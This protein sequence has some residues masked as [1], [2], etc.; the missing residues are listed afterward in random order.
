[1]NFFSGWTWGRSAFQRRRMGPLG[2]RRRC[3][4]KVVNALALEILESRALPSFTAPLGYDAGP[5]PRSVAVG[6]FN[7]D[8]IPDLAVANFVLNGTVSVL[9][10]N[11]DGSFQRA[12]SFAAGNNPVAVAVGDLTGN[13]ILDLVVADN[14]GIFGTPALNVLLGNGD[15]TFQAPRTVAPGIQPGAVAVGDFNGDG[16]QD[17]AVANG[18]NTVSMFLGNGDGSFRRAM[19]YA[20]GSGPDSIA[21]GDFNHDGTLDLAVANYFN[22]TVSVLLGIGDGSF[23]TARNFAAERNPTSVAVGDFTGSGRLDLAVANNGSNTVSV[24]LGNGDGSFQRPHNYTVGSS[25]MMV[26]VGDFIGDGIQDLAVTDSNSGTISVLLGAGNGSFLP[27]RALSAGAVPYG[28]AVGDFNGDGTQDLA[29]TDLTSAP[30][31]GV[32]VL[33]GTGT[34]SFQV[35]PSFAVGIS[36]ESVAVADLNGDG[37]PDLVVANSGGYFDNGSVS[38]LLGNGDGSF[39]PARSFAVGS[40]PRS[41][42]VGDFN[43]DGIPDL[44]VANSGSNNVSVLLGNG[45]GSFQPAR[46]FAV[47]SVPWSVAAADLAGDGVLDLV[48][49]NFNANDVSILLGTG[50][51]TFQS[52]RTFAAGTRPRSVAV[53]DFDG[54]GI[55]DL[56]VA[57]EGDSVTGSGGGVSILRGTGGGTFQAARRFAAGMNPRSVAVGDFN[58]DGTLDLAVA[59]RANYEGTPGVSVLL[60]T[61]NG[62]FQPARTFAAG[63]FPIAV[64][65]GDFNGDGIQDLAVAG[66]GGTRVLLGTGNGTFQTTNVSYVTGDSAAV[67]VGDFNGDGL[68][69]LAAAANRANA[70]F[71]LANDGIWDSSPGAPGGPKPRPEPVLPRLLLENVKQVEAGTAAV[72]S[73]GATV[74]L[75]NGNQAPQGADQGA[76]PVAPVA[77]SATKPTPRAQVLARAQAMTPWLVDR[78]LAELEADGLWDPFPDAPSR[79]GP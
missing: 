67:A 48:V 29:V 36:P 16:I 45:D 74:P 24:L 73:P 17:L 77:V 53:G 72:P 63:A 30:T 14:G 15:G 61:G 13:G 68:P 40:F 19:D 43:G 62:T 42:A 46:S 27:A 8:G 10:G 65:V 69:D 79:S 39:R 20:V 3:R 51:G 78:L 18:S 4:G 32:S 31:G 58:G 23:Q 57:D 56:A 70:V 52:A 66:G 7:G 35:P 28:M 55:P 21:V 26:V 38:V 33:L 54:D 59:D 9:L 37:I 41:V 6:D 44:A 1:M 60:G 71:I 2:G 75:V 64:A 5:E 49:A 22:N 11:G 47:G 50:D 12:R 76:K 25:P 34:G